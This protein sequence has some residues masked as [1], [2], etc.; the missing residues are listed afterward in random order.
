[1]RYSNPVPRFRLSTLLILFACAA[2]G[3][4]ATRDLLGAIW[5]AIRAAMVVG[6]AAA[7]ARANSLAAP[8]R[9]RRWSSECPNVCH[10]LATCRRRGDV[11]LP[12]N[13]VDRLDR[14]RALSGPQRPVLLRT[15]NRCRRSA[16]DLSSLPTACGVG[17]RASTVAS[18]RRIGWSIAVALLLLLAACSVIDQRLIDYLVHRAAADIEA[19]ITPGFQRPGVYPDHLS[20]GFRSFWIAFAAA[21]TVPLGAAFLIRCVETM[22]F[23]WRKG[24]G[25]GVRRMPYGATDPIADGSTGTTIHR[26]SPDLAGQDLQRS[27][28]DSLAW[29]ILAWRSSRLR[30]PTS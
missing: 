27:R 9:L 29:R 24:F 5:P 7:S 12:N 16:P 28:S 30:R 25:R 10:H 22:E 6:F 11:V 13:R 26:V 19:S 4:A 23:H 20:E 18:S 1:M 14:H 3:L 8:E 15:G 21:A 2:I 17:G